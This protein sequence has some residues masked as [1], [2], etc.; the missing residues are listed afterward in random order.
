MEGFFDPDW[1]R[2]KYAD[3]SIAGLNPLI[4]FIR[5][6]AAERRDPNAFFDTD[7]Y[8]RH[9]PD[10][11]ASGI[12]PLLHYLSAGAA[13][14]RNPHPRFDATWYVDQHPEAAA[15]P[16]VFHMRTG[17][18]LGYPTERTFDI[19]DWMPSAEAPL[20][21][22][23][24]RGADIIIPVYR[25]LQE[26][27]CC[28]ESVLAD[29]DRLPGRIIVIDDKSPE[30]K[31]SAWLDRLARAKRITLIR[32]R[33][34]MGFVASVNSGMRAADPLNDVVL[35]NSDTEVPVG[36]LP[37]LAAQAW[38][39][40]EVAS[41]SP[42]SNNATICG[43]PRDRGWNIPFGLS[44]AELDEVCRGVNA[45]RSVEVPTPVGFCMY[46]RR[47]ALNTVGLFDEQAFGRGYGEENDFCLRAASVGWKHL[48]ACDTFVYHAGSVSFGDESEIRSAEGQK[49]LAE[50]Y[51]NY[52]SAVER[53]VRNDRVGPFRFVVTAAIFRRSGLPV[54]LLVCH[55]L[56]GGVRRHL[57]LLVKR[58]EGRAHFLLLAATDRG[59]SLSV[60]A[61]PGHA[62][63]VLTEERTE[64]LA[65]VVRLAAVRRV[66]IHHLAGVDLDIRALIHHLGLPFDV[67]VHDYFAICPQVNLLPWSEGTYCGEPG[68]A[69]CNACIAARSSHGARE[70]L[71]WRGEK[72]WQFREADRVL[73]PSADVRDRLMRHGLGERALV[74]PHD[75]EPAGPWVVRARKPT[76]QLRIAVLGVLANHKGA[77]IV[78][79]FAALARDA[80]IEV[81]LI[82]YPEPEFPEELRPLLH[83]TGKYAE[84]DLPDLLR[85]TA[86]HVVW[87][88]APWPES[89]SYTLS[90]ALAA[91][92][93]IVATRIGSFPERLADR[94]L[95]WVVEPTQS[96][97]EWLALFG[98]V[99]SALRAA[100]PR[101]SGPNRPETP[102]FYA[103]A[104]LA[105]VS[106]PAVVRTSRTIDLRR[107]GRP[108]IVVIPER[109]GDGLLSPCAYIR[110]LQP[111]DHPAIGGEM[112]VVLTDAATALRYRADVILTQRYAIEDEAT[113]DALVR[114]AQETSA[115]LVY[116]MDDDL[117]N[118]PITHADAAE[119]RPKAGTVRRLIK[120]ASTVWVST[121]SLAE[122]VRPI[123]SEIRVVPN[124][125]DERLWLYHAP[126]RDPPFG[127][128]RALYMGTVTHESDFA[129]VAPALERL[130]RDFAQHLRIDIIGV[131]ARGEL[132]TGL[133]RV[134]VSPN[135]AQSYPGFVNWITSMPAWDIGL[136]PLD[137]TAFNQAK[138][139]IKTFDYAALGLAV[140]A[141]DMPVYRD[142]PAVREGG[143]LIGNDPE[144]WYGAIS[145][146]VRDRAERE[147]LTRGAK[148]AFAV[149]GT[150]V[151]QA[152]ERRAAWAAVLE[153][154]RIF[155]SASRSRARK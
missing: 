101:T 51:P 12:V 137:D 15:N 74:A 49:V 11:A 78:G 155:M 67:T 150:L 122:R 88:P 65:Q 55:D 52:R 75:P 130:A 2:E 110:L 66:H 22:P 32:N 93:P 127:P 84:A 37:R 97:D 6:G 124:G 46:I 131:T 92:L 63:L 34:N 154:P 141:S 148:A 9:Y 73:C 103:E 47:D 113:A 64:E 81:R 149:S 8:L 30:P 151:S 62:V 1:Y 41:V 143:L 146:L 114:H 108:Q 82:G 72:S 7:W 69:T 50:R 54:I 133:N 98:Q 35:L 5:F 48:L 33:R 139:N 4:H 19:R 128:V 121:T 44:V 129:I 39:R 145:R 70:I 105:P 152:A 60:P 83:E 85:E 68:P 140:L 56:G 53:H 126:P 24:R 115:A 118:I 71:S 29:T 142:S 153:G 99:M 132:P 14:L 123:Q 90:A 27:K 95:T 80:G 100:K 91:E 111:L 94:P 17:R 20:R 136:A 107:P 23:R 38:S 147:R 104:Y 36:W 61:I 42:F 119:L 57:D 109:I 45:G 144:S 96:A 28:L 106:A 89:Y 86:P 116:D 134:G 117:L 26:T 125:L 40:R 13:E 120:G 21:P 87:F 135:G 31:L 58:L 3:V 10:V 76:K 77:H 112:D 79:T 43:Y 59:V 138:S 18:H 16:L 25:G 102:D